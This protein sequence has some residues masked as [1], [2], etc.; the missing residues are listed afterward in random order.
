MKLSLLILGLVIVAVCGRSPVKRV[1]QCTHRGVKYDVGETFQM[2][3]N[4]CECKEGGYKN[5]RSCTKNKCKKGP[6]LTCDHNG[7]T[8]W[9]GETFMDDCNTCNCLESGFAA[10]TRKFCIQ[11]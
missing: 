3:C 2:R 1:R 10:C 5:Y 4:T 7:K 6:G 11:Y 8:Y 9:V